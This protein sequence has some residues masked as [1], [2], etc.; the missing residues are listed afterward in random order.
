MQSAKSE[1]PPM[2]DFLRP[3]L[4]WASKRSSGFNLP[5]ITEAMANHFNLSPEAREE[6]TAADN[7]YCV[8]DKTTR[9]INPHLKEAGLVRSTHRGH[10]EITQAGKDEA[11]ASDERMTYSYLMSNFAS[12]RKYRERIKNGKSK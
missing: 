8:Y 10:Y 11:F 7:A 3:V 1:V 4:R 5:E 9:A 2:T 12:Y 6:R